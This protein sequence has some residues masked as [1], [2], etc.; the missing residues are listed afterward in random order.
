MRGRRPARQAASKRSQ[1][2]FTRRAV[3]SDNGSGTTGRFPSINLS[4]LHRSP[5]WSG[6]RL[7]ILRSRLKVEPGLADQV[8]PP[9]HGP[10]GAAETNG[11]LV[12][13][14]ALHPPEGNL[15]QRVVSQAIQE[16]GVLLGHDRGELG[17]RLRP[18]DPL[19]P[20]LPSSA[21]H[22]FRSASADTRSPPRFWRRWRCRCA[23]TFRAV[24]TTSK[25]QRSSRP[26]NCGN[27][28]RATPVQKLSNAL[29]AASSPS[30]SAAPPDVARTRRGRAAR[31]GR[32]T[33]PIRA[34]PPRRP[35]PGA[36]RASA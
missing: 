16:P 7:S 25:R 4:P 21:Q 15:T 31:A 27:R 20:C 5:N 35:W 17:C 23:D 1:P 10:P 14:V 24:M 18:D 19:Q 30:A 34:R 11:D 6:S 22:A 36:H 2:S 9:G 33:D 3:G 8:E 12:V 32:N 13:G 29:R 28:P 26:D